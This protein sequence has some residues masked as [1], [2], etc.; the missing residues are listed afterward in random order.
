[1]DYARGSLQAQIQKM[2]CINLEIQREYL[3]LDLESDKEALEMAQRMCAGR[4]VSLKPSATCKEEGGKEEERDRHMEREQ[5]GMKPN[6]SKEEVTEWKGGERRGEEEGKE[7]ERQETRH[8]NT[9][10]TL[11]S[12]RGNA[13]REEEQREERAEKLKGKKGKVGDT[14]RERVKKEKGDEMEMQDSLTMEI[15]VDE[16][17]KEVQ[18]EANG[19]IERVLIKGEGKVAGKE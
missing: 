16:E 13:K 17:E 10:D 4:A 11:Y 15:V 3:E 6:L 9:A 1:M 12:G 5:E 7:R 18:R 8:Q 19:K 2:N 14:N